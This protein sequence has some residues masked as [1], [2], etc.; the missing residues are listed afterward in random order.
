MQPIPAMNSST[1]AMEDMHGIFTVVKSDGSPGRF[2]AV[3]L[4]KMILGYMI[5][6]YDIKTMDGKRPVDTIFQLARYP[7]MAAAISI[8]RRH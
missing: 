5:L 7:D 6:Q 1:L 3:D 8:R 4:I 2:F